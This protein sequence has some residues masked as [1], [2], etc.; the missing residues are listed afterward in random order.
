MFKAVQLI[1]TFINGILEEWILSEG[2]IF[3]RVYNDTKKRFKD[4]EY[5]HTSTVLESSTPDLE[6]GSIIETRNSVYLLGK[7]AAD[8]IIEKQFDEKQIKEAYE[9]IRRIHGTAD[10]ELNNHVQQIKL[11]ATIQDDHLFNMLVNRFKFA[12][13]GVRYMTGE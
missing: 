7:P 3:G 11:A 10:A 6:E 5:I 12:D 13:D 8:M 1:N 9:A 2:M 4:G